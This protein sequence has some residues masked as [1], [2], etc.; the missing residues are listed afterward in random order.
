MLP[1]IQIDMFEV[2]LGAGLLVQFRTCDQ[3]VRVLAD[4]G[5]H[6]SGYPKDHV[7]RKLT[8]AFES[9]DAS[10]SRRIDLIVGTHY[11]ADHLDGLVPIIEDP[12]IEIGEAW[13]P[14]VANDNLKARV[15]GLP[16]RRRPA[17]A[18]V[19]RAGR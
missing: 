1:S 14:P 2:Q 16:G 7:H 11:D 8:D 3:V 9:F 4:A 18:A 12:T 15:G 5:V 19:R 6:A 17:G 13:L 10:A